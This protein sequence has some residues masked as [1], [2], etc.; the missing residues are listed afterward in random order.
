MYI[1]TEPKLYSGRTKY[2]E[3]VHRNMK[4][5]TENELLTIWTII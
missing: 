5:V 2:N 3:K 4:Q 1:M